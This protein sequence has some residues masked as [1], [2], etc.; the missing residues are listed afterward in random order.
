MTG[1]EDRLRQDLPAL[2]DMLMEE[3]AAQP[4]EAAGVIA[5]GPSLV[6]ELG[7]QP[8]HRR[9]RWS[10]VAAAAAVAAVVG[11]VALVTT[12]D[13][14]EVT[15][16][17]VPAVQPDAEA[18]DAASEPEAP[19]TDVGGPE[20]PS[21]QIDVPNGEPETPTDQAPSGQPQLRDEPPDGQ[22]ALPTEAPTEPP[23]GEA[24][25]PT[26]APAEQ[27]T[28]DAVVGGD[29]TLRPGEGVEVITGR[30][31][32]SSGYFQAAL[33]K[34][35]LEELGYSVSDPSQFEMGPSGAYTAMAIG[36][37]DYWPNSWYPGHYE[38]HAAEL[39]DGSLVGDRVSVVGEMLFEGLLQ[40]F[41][42]TKSF[43]DTY[44][45][46]TMDDLNRNAEALAAFD[47]S[48]P[49]PGN[50]K[51]DIFGCSQHWTCDDII[52]NMIAFGG[53][54]NIVQTMGGYDVMFTQAVD[55]VNEGV[56]MVIYT[57][58]P[59][60]HITRLRPGDNV[61]WMGVEN[62]LDA[63]NPTGVQQ[64]HEH[65]Q[66]GPD[67]TG[68][69]AAIGEDQCPSAADEPDGKCPIG[70]LAAHIL[71]TANTEFLE[72]NPAAKALFEAVKLTV[73]EVS[74]AAETVRTGADAN[75]LAA[76]WIADNRERVDAWLAAA[77]A[78]E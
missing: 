71:V 1:L 23:G 24:E 7:A 65:D 32:W 74:L 25:S 43:A 34:L 47:T 57:W 53:W 8:A 48:D 12:S 21:D 56:P 54:D 10:A 70:W 33:Y 78:A 76:Q 37:M 68:G 38:W 13:G 18:Q 45:V 40:G 6:V 17:E 5:D 15:T 31:D 42:V 77:R 75:V 41:L 59:S 66:R 29:G 16:T 9:R 73:V 26:E 20:T 60:E 58:T 63:S 52:E 67:G 19:S 36:D 61:Y 62:I 51:A 27:S 30:A 39:P 11:V 14:T 22:E 3:Q 64:G 28:L 49:V 35:L 69:F 50:G 2:A 44:G 4:E 46:Y 72:A 55:R